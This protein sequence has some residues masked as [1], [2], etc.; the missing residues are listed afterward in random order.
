MPSEVK[1]GPSVDG[2]L[3]LYIGIPT[4]VLMGILATITFSSYA[5]LI[6]LLSICL[7]W[8]LKRNGID[9][10]ICLSDEGLLIQNPLRIME[11]SWSDVE[12]ITRRVNIV[13]KFQGGDHFSVTSY[14]E[15]SFQSAFRRRL[16]LFKSRAH[17]LEVLQQRFA[18]MSSAN[19]EGGQTFHHSISWNMPSWK[20][21]MSWI[22][23]VVVTELIV[24][25]AH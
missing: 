24:L 20:V 21:L 13:V 10:Q 11:T 18:E 19:P 17:V 25:V 8:Y 2:L 7:I 5:A 12:S 16:G 4:V 22:S 15:M 14:A 23:L 3:G 6:V 1:F 9:S